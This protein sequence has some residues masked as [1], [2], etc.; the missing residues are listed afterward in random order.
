MRW[1]VLIVVIVAG[2]AGGWWYMHSQTVKAAAD[3]ARQE[4]EQ[5]RIIPVVAV[6]VRKQDVPIYLDGLGIAQASATVTIKTQI[7]G[8][9]TEVN[10]VEGQ[11]VKAGDVLAR[12]DPRA[13]QAALDQA[14]AKKAQDQAMLANARL[15]VIRYA[16]LAASAYTSAQ[17][18]DTARATVEQDAAQVNQDQAAIDTARVN[19]SYTT[20]TSPIDGRVGIRLVDNGNIVHAADTTGICVI[21]TLKPISVI[22]TL[23][24]Q[25]LGDVARAMATGTPEVLALP[26]DNGNVILDRGTLSV[27]DN[28]VD[29]STGT[30]RLKATFPN[31]QLR[32][33][34]GSFTN[35]RLKTEIRTGV[36][37]IP[38]VA[39]QRGPNG[40]YVYVIKPDNT[41]E[42]R[43]VSIGHEDPTTSIILDGLKEGE[44]VVTDG[45]SR[46]ND[47]RRVTVSAA[48]AGD[49]TTLRGRPTP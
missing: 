1:F 25:S 21:T 23:P 29:S 22:F 35:V 39:V 9:L 46:L 34:P 16:K 42:R 41:A 8:K 20:I 11:D 26:Q 4:A 12:I 38:P 2:S 40:A 13:Y 19:L 28:Q 30:I 6:A 32:I 10:F 3:I 47:G 15:D 33:W 31:P 43:T 36:L 24:Q 17:Q 7:D 5:R 45:A 14:I 27:L 48:P 49:P 37:T 44:R 18:Y